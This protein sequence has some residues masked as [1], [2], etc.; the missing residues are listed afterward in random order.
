MANYHLG[1]RT[2]DRLLVWIAAN[3]QTCRRDTASILS[4]QPC[5]T[6]MDGGD[7]SLKAEL[8]WSFQSPR[9]CGCRVEVRPLS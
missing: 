5:A 9:G 6:G 4:L 3:R 8:W 2:L 1:K 7:V